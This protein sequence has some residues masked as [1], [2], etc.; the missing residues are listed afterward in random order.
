MVGVS[1]RY[2]PLSAI[3]PSKSDGHKCTPQ[4][5]QI[6][7]ESDSNPRYNST[8]ATQYYADCN[9][10]HTTRAV[11]TLFRGVT[12]VGQQSLLIPR[13]GNALQSSIS[14]VRGLGCE[15]TQPSTTLPFHPSHST[16]GW[17]MYFLCKKYQKPW[18]CGFEGGEKGAM[19]ETP[20]V[21]QVTWSAFPSAITPFPPLSPQNP[22]AVNAHPNALKFPRRVIEI[23]TT[24]ARPQN[25][26]PATQYYADCNSTHTTRA[27]TTLFR[28]VTLAG[29]QRLLIPRN[30]NAL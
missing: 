5:S 3:I 20:A 25:T 1:E 22:T 6:P 21:A 23:P 10:I 28:G 26:T 14:Y 12:L 15:Q 17:G 11:T 24:I 27:V 4:R 29:Q 13:N 19:A 2:H 7:A 9:S 16:S 8:P 30:G 18:P